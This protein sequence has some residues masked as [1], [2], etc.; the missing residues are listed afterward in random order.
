MFH[1]QKNHPRVII[2]RDSDEATNQSDL[3][4][5]DWLGLLSPVATTDAPDVNDDNKTTLIND[6]KL[7]LQPSKYVYMEVQIWCTGISIL[8]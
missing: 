4:L 3:T 6:I 1:F 8:L 5:P 2:R 7:E